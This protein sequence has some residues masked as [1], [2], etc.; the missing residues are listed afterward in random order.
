[1]VAARRTW[2]QHSSEYEDEGGAFRC[3]SQALRVA[4][5]D[6]RG[7]WMIQWVAPFG[8]WNNF[9]KIDRTHATSETDVLV[10]MDSWKVMAIEY[11]DY[12][13]CNSIVHQTRMVASGSRIL[14]PSINVVGFSAYPSCLAQWHSQEWHSPPRQQR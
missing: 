6:L 8:I 12:N 11:L 1:M 2:W 9:L 5:I 4:E 14:D 7:R 10:P 13:I 3:R